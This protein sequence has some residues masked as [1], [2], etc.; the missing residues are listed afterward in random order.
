[1]DPEH[2]DP[3]QTTQSSVISAFC[4]N[5]KMFHT[6]PTGN[7]YRLGHLLMQRLEKLG[8]IALEQKVE[9][10]PRFSTSTLFGEPRGK[11]F[12]LLEGYDLHGIHRTLLAFSGQYNTMWTVPGWA[13]P[14]FDV[15][16]WH[17]VNDVAERR[18]KR[19]G[20]CMKKVS[21]SS[22]VHRNLKLQRRQLSR[23]LMRKLHNLYKVTNFRGETASLATFFPEARGIPT[24]TGDCCAPKLLHAARLQNIHP[25]G[26][27]EFYWGRPNRSGKKSHQTYYHPCKEKCLP[28]L[29]YMLCGLNQG[30]HTTSRDNHADIVFR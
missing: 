6:L 3:L 1:M 29:G 13:P 24:G 11:M 18:I 9:P 27:A 22:S 5:C 25:T 23:D 17:Q 7:C 4:P 20:E 16:E 12:G 8:H 19:L 21:L 14:L 30:E 28:I 2:N 10:D 26:M 15:Q